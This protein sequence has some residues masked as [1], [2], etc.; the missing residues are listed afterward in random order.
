MKKGIASVVGAAGAAIV[1]S[2]V[3]L[4]CQ[5][6]KP[7]TAGNSIQTEQTGLAPNGDKTHQTIDFSLVFAN[8]DAIKTWKVEM[9]TGS[10]PQKQ[11]S[12]DAKNLPATLSWDGKSESWVPG[13]GRRLHG[14]IDGG[15]WQ[16]DPGG[17]GREQFFRAG[18]HA[19]HGQRELQPAAVQP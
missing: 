15:L 9:A 3:L 14:A 10:G 6:A 8:R 5:T 11:W 12:G 19:S 4:S 18:Y 1:L 7:N 2:V 13:A 16:R 17:H